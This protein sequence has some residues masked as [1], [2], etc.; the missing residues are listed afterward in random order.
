[1]TVPTKKRRATKGEGSLYQR[2][3]TWWYKDPT[4][5]CHSCKTK[6]KSEALDFK[7]NWIVQ[8]KTGVDPSAPPISS[9]VTVDELLDDYL[10]HLKLNNKRSLKIV[11]GVLKTRI[12]PVFGKRLASSIQ[13]VDAK[14]YRTKMRRT[15]CKQTGEVYRDS[16]INRH[17]SLLLSA[18]IYANERQTPRKLEHVPY[19]PMADESECVRTGFIEESGYLA[20]L[21]ELP[22]SIKPLLTCG[23][24]VSTRKGELLKIRWSQVNLDA[25]LIEMEAR[26]AKNKTGRYVPIYGDMVSVLKEQ[27]RLRDD[28]FSETEEVFFWH[29]ADCLV[30]HGGLRSEPGSPIKDFYETWRAAVTRAAMNCLEAKRPEDVPADLLFHDLRRSAQRNMRRAGIDQSLRMKISGHKTN[31]MEKRYNIVDIDD[32]LGAAAKMTEWA[33]LERE[34]A[35]A[36]R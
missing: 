13:T 12:R 22:S 21:A 33:K 1:V 15:I 19:F 17:L 36:T 30:G 9:G 16:T 5:E 25:G 4:G 34:R 27:K 10:E 32:V 7:Q 2:G 35:T 8:F 23:Y 26:T 29:R 20:L 18:L 28:E 11:K 14:S 3:E 24:H 31:S 6:I